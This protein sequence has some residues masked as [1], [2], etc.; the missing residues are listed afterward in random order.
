MFEGV[1]SQKTMLTV[2]TEEKMSQIQQ[3]IDHTILYR[4]KKL[5]ISGKI[6][7]LENDAKS[8]LKPGD[9]ASI[10]ATD[11]SLKNYKDYKKRH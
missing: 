7:T 5:P 10:A 9:A 3:K 8:S 6:Q 4:I 2:M 1:V 11:L